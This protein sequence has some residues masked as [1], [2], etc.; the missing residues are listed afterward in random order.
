MIQTTEKRKKY[1]FD[2]KIKFEKLKTL[3]VNIGNICNNHCKHCHVNAGPNGNNL[4]SVKTMD[5]ILN[6]LEKN[7]TITLDITG[8][9]PE[10]HPAIKYFVKTASEKTD[11]VMLRTNLTILTEYSYLDMAEFFAENKITLIASLPC[12]T[13]QNVEVQRG[14]GTFDASI[15]ALKRLNRLGYAKDKNL[16]LNLVYNPLGPSLPAPQ[17]KLENEYK[18]HLKEN[19]GIVFNS[20]FTITNMPLGR[21]ETTLRLSGEQ[22]KYMKILIENFNPDN[23]E[24]VMCKTLISIDWQGKLYNCDFNQ[25][26]QMPLKNKSKKVLTVKDLPAICKKQ[27][28]IRTGHHCYGCTAGS[29]SGCTGALN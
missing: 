5:D 15:E 11:K 19:Y 26:T 9:A 25:I 28:E 13:K 27:M 24:S 18:K 3:Q 21:F 8:G 12:Y 20:L 14:L 29:G 23:I 7:P 17:K 22:H 1:S 10:M 4:M 6:F 16:E 2:K